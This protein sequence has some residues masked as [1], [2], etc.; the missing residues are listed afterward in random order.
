[1]KTIVITGANS[2]I[3]FEATKQLAKLNHRII[4]VCRNEQRAQEACQKINCDRNNVSYLIADLSNL[5]EIKAL[6][7]KLLQTTP[8]I[9]VLINNAADFDISNQKPKFN[10][11]G[12]SCQFCTNVLA[13]FILCEKLMP[14]LRKNKGKIINISTQGLCMYPFL[15]LDF[16]NL[17]AEKSYKADKTYYQNKLALLMFSLFMRDKYPDV[18][19]H[20]IRVA[21]VAIDITRYPNV[22]KFS[23]RLY[24]IKS[25][26][27]ISPATMA[28]AYVSLATGNYDGFLYNEKMKVVKANR[29]AYHKEAQEK[30]Y[31]L[32]LTY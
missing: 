14:V 2:G 16:D 23:Q 31:Q 7:E 22:S 19:V 6:A 29:F 28:K 3:G 12:I 20:A 17:N 32:L 15:S 13:P 21:N 24:K 25:S 27:S 4:M 1:M 26:F 18:S 11:Q 10:S 9:D 5:C 30:L 8:T